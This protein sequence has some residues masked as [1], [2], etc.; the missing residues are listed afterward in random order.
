VI[1]S[2]TSHTTLRAFIQPKPNSNCTL[3]SLKSPRYGQIG[4]S[5]VQVD[6]SNRPA[7]LARIESQ[8]Y[9]HS[10]PTGP[11]A[12]WYLLEPSDFWPTNPEFILLQMHIDVIWTHPGTELTFELDLELM[13]TELAALITT[14]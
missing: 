4:P 5:V 6:H 8:E 7:S 10:I 12:D 14:I 2:S 13:C 9:Q 11:T 3:S 1:L